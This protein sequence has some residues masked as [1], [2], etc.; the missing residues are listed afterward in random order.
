MT[1]DQIATC[2]DGSLAHECG[3]GGGG[4][5]LTPS[6]APAFTVIVVVRPAASLWVTTGIVSLHSMVKWG[7]TILCFFGRFIQIWKSSRGLSVVDDSSG[8]ISQCTMPR[9]AVIHCTSPVE[10]RAVAPSESL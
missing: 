9:P 3:G 6:T 4:P 7:S 8:N 10:K 5:L 1:I 2:D